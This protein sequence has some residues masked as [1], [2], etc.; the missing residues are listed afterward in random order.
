MEMEIPDADELEW[1]SHQQDEELFIP[2]EEDE[3]HLLTSNSTFRYSAQENGGRKRPYPG[4]GEEDDDDIFVLKDNE[5]RSRMEEPPFDNEEGLQ[6]SP[7]ENEIEKEEFEVPHRMEEPPF[8]DEE[9]LQPPPKETEIEKEEFEVPRR[10]AGDI[11]GDCISITGPSGERVY[12]KLSPLPSITTT[13][14]ANAG[15]L[16]SESIHVVIER[17][18]KD[19]FEQ[20]CRATT[21]GM[22]DET[23]LCS[24]TTNEQ[25]WVDKYAPKSFTELLSDEQTNREVLRWLKQWD[26][27]VFGYKNTLTSNEV[28][29]AL[30]RRSFLSQSNGSFRSKNFSYKDSGGIQTSKAQDGVQKINNLSYSKENNANISGQSKKQQADDDRPDEKVLLLC[31]PPGLGKTTLA[32][33]AAKHCGYHVVEINASDDRSASIVERKILDVVQMNSVMADSKPKCLVIDEIDGALGDGK[34]AIEVLLKMLSSEKKYTLE[35]ENDGSNTQS[36]NATKKKGSSKSGRLSRPVI[37]I[38]NDLYAPALRSLRQVA[39]VHIFVQPSASRVVSRLKYICTKEGFKASARGL[40]TLAEFTECDIRACLNTLQFL[41]RK[42]EI[43]NV[44]D[45]GSQIVG[46]KDMTSS[47]FDIWKEVLQKRKSKFQ[48]PTMNSSKQEV[49]NF[50][51]LHDIFSSHGDY[52]LAVEGIHENFLHVRYHDSAMEKTVKCLDFFC[53]SDLL[54]QRIMR[55]QHFFLNVYQP[56]IIVAIHCLIA[57]V[58]KPNI[59]W[60]KSHQRCRTILSEKKDLLK[61]WLNSISPTISRFLSLNSIV[62]DV[63]TSLLYILSPPSL[64]PV[65]SRLLSE[66]EQS[67]IFELVNA[68]VDYAVTYKKAKILSPHGN[69]R[70][71]AT[72]GSLELC[73]CPPINEFVTFKDYS[74]SHYLLSSA[75]RQ[76]LSHEFEKQTILRDF[77]ARND[78]ANAVATLLQEVSITEASETHVEKDTDNLSTV[79]KASKH[80]ASDNERNKCVPSIVNLFNSKGLNREAVQNKS[81]SSVVDS[82]SKLP[83]TVKKPAASFDFFERFKKSSQKGFETSEKSSGNL[84]TSQ[85]DSRPLLFKFNEGF[86]NAVKRPV[87][88]RELL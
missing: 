73:F 12:A 20:A 8:V 82:K 69:Q 19:M 83:G 27:C 71:D 39:R 37:C 76:I 26:H 17:V 55:S 16:L 68:M 65:A 53:N 45:V 72:L 44:V 2:D 51:R 43:L 10:M 5:K 35:K 77:N 57:Q 74:P 32:H 87:R 60:P 67:Q 54:S 31:G 41:K 52:E 36:L 21:E 18:E 34:G 81:I 84:L 66:K 86:T 42:K 40:T 3:F 49:E 9:W 48:G 46:R 85:R 88:M 47:I 56:S 64:K 15:G 78:R 25:L 4:E 61:S 30:K 80:F 23:T 14:N 1:L 28:L 33:V 11:Q 59:E 63:I 50:I 29:S 6:P 58:E 24:Q 22:R 75:M 38:C 79:E 7:K 70:Q 13:R 62:E